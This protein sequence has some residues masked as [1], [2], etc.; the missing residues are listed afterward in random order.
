MRVSKQTEKK[1]S[2]SVELMHVEEPCVNY[3]D[4]CAVGG[5][6]VTEGPMENTPQS[7]YF[8]PFT[9]IFGD[10]AVIAIA[11]TAGV[12]PRPTSISV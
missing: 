5:R 8:L 6:G 7:F 12:D 1:Y 10:G 4:R 2:E 11:A 3:G 9:D